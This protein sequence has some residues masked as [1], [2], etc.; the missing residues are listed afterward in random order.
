GTWSPTHLEAQAKS[1]GSQLRTAGVNLNLAPVLGTVPKGFSN[2]P[3]GA[4]DREYGH[5]PS[6]VAAAGTAFERGMLAAGEA[7]TLKHFPGLGRVSANTDTSAGVTDHVTTYDDPYLQPFRAGVAAGSPFV[8][9]TTA[10]YALIDPGVPAAF[11]AKIIGGMLRGEMGFGGVVISDSLDAVQ[12]QAWSP[13]TRAL[14]FIGAGGDLALVTSASAIPAMVAAVYDKAATDP[15]FHTVVD[16]AALHVLAAK[17]RYGLL[18]AVSVTPPPTTTPEPP[19][20]ATTTPPPTTTPEPPP[21]TAPTTAPL[22]T[23]PAS[24]RRTTTP[25]PP[26]PAATTAPRESRKTHP[27]SVRAAPPAAT[28]TTSGPSAPPRNAQQAGSA[29]APVQGRVAATSGSGIPWWT[30][31][32]VAMVVIAFGA[33]AAMLIRRRPVGR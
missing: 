26:Q 24:A 1:W 10:D 23:A 11:S 8:M 2:P 9:M 16:D 12:V 17:A 14:D 5:T 21:A 29:D 25:R 30:W 20:A 33:A 28:P 6:V 32:I 27:T 15:A 18:A 4:L 19:P 31:A 3:I 22:S 13:A 7:T